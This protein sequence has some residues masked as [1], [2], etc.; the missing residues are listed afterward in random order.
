MSE[1]EREACLFFAARRLRA[2]QGMCFLLEDKQISDPRELS[3][4]MR[5][6]LLEKQAEERRIPSSN[7]LELKVKIHHWYFLIVLNII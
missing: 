7:G 3:I 1:S 6:M 4:Y 2:V 5:G